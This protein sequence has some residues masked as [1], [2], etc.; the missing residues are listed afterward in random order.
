ML[1]RRVSVPLGPQGA[2]PID[3]AGPGIPRV[4]HVVHVAPGCRTP[5]VGEFLGVLLDPP[6]GLGRRI[7]RLGDLVLEQ[8]LHRPLRPHHGD[9]GG[10][11][12][13]VEVAPDVLGAHDVV[14]PAIRLPG[15]DSELRHCGLA[16][17]VQQLGPVLDDAAV[18]LGDAGQEAG[19]VFK[20]DERDVEGVTEPDEPGSLDRGVDVEDAGQHRGLV[21]DDPDRLRHPAVRTP[22][23]CCP[24]TRRA[25]RER[26][27]RP[28]PAG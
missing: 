26:S 5:R 15:D 4:D 3:Q 25:P 7:G 27:R 18:L 10:G 2:E 20:G 22:P 28:R 11:P 8:D 12:G 19:D 13:E 14:G 16:V 24:H 6:G 1:L 21:G 23:A 17:G 9:L